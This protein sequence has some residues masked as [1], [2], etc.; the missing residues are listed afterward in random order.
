MFINPC[1]D[2]SALL[3][4]IIIDSRINLGLK[5]K[6]E[7]FQTQILIARNLMNL[8]RNFKILYFT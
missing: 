8:N 5:T 7:L 3:R 6:I 4:F 1:S 2:K